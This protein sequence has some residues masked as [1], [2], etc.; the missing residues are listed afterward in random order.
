MTDIFVAIRC[1]E[2]PA[3]FVQT[4]LDQLEK[5]LVGA[6]KGIPHGNTRKWATPRRIAVAVENVAEQSPL[7]EKVVTGPPVA[8]AFRNGE[9]TKA[10][11]GF[12][13][14]KGITVDD[15]TTIDTPRGTVIAAKTS[16]G[17]EKTTERL[18]EK[19]ESIILGLSLIHI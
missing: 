13:R 6:L 12:A 17:G 10:A 2:L 8:A 15:L 9:A 16:F 4:A 7:E 3:R 11:I 14:S 5:R 19:I 1:E 18:K